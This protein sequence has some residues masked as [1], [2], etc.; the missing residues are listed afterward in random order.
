MSEAM[1]RLERYKDVLEKCGIDPDG[2]SYSGEEDA[3]LHIS[4]EV[5]LARYCVVTQCGE[6]TYAKAN[7]ETLDCAKGCALEYINDDLFQESPVAIIDLDTGERLEPDFSTV[8][9]KAEVAK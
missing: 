6:F 2:D 8:Q 4:G 7:C 3:Q 1:T 9:W 5:P